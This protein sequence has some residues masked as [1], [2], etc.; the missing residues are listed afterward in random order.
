MKPKASPRT[1]DSHAVCLVQ[2]GLLHHRFT[3]KCLFAFEI[4]YGMIASELED[5]S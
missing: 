2:D 3:E 4:W 1:Q 5:F